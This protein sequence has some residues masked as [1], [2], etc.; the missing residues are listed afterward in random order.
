MVMNIG[1]MNIVGDEHRVMMNIG[2]MNI[3]GD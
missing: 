1:V 3:G 2:V